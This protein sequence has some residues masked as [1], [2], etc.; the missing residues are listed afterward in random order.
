MSFMKN[1]S[2]FKLCNAQEKIMNGD[3]PKSP[4][5]VDVVENGIPEEIILPIKNIK[6]ESWSRSV[7]KSTTWRITGIL[8]L[9][10]VSYGIT[11][12]WIDTSIITLCYHGIQLILYV[13]HERIWQNIFWGISN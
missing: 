2:C 12:K 1:L 6:K 13:A 8:I 3:I 11:N 10:A 7:V 5:N 4:N 9:G